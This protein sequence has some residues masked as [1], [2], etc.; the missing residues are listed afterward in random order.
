MATLLMGNFATLPPDM[1]K[2]IINLIPEDIFSLFMLNKRWYMVLPLLGIRATSLAKFK[3]YVMECKAKGREIGKHAV[4]IEQWSEG[5]S[6]Y[7]INGWV[8]DFYLSDHFT[9]YTTPRSLPL[10]KQCIDRLIPRANMIDSL[11]SCPWLLDC[12]MTAP[13]HQKVQMLRFG[14]NEKIYKSINPSNLNALIVCRCT[15][16]HMFLD[17]FYEPTGDELDVYVYKYTPLLVRKTHMYLMIVEK[18]GC[19]FHT[20]CHYA[21][22]ASEIMFRKSFVFH[23]KLFGFTEDHF[24][25]MLPYMTV[26]EIKLVGKLSKFPKCTSI[27]YD[28]FIAAYPDATDDDIMQHCCMALIPEIVVVRAAK[29]AK[30]LK[31]VKTA[32]FGHLSNK[33]GELLQHLLT[34]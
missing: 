16:F 8:D 9:H 19:R 11:N 32:L 22:S 26:E 34:N 31:Q 13:D 4:R 18:L 23:A 15:Q 6:E 1:L 30:T 29:K 10:I 27:D 28:R 20:I 7:R 3:F 2:Y 21:R 24:I 14:H 33:K 25:G 5:S 17:G 12:L